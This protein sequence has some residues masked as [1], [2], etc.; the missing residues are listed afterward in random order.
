[1]N[2]DSINNSDDK[3]LYLNSKSVQGVYEWIEAAVFSLLCVSLIFTFVMR[4]VGV[5]GNSMKNTLYDSERLI[6][7]RSFYTPKRG[8]IIIIKRYPEEPLVKRI[9]AVGGDRLKIDDETNQVILNGKVLHEDY[10]LGV[11]WREG[12]PPEEQ[13]I[14]QGTVFVMGDNRQNS[15]DSRMMEQVGYVDVEDIMGKAIFRFFPLSRAGG[16]Y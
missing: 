16:L 5:D 9:I 3:I 13:V 11:T 12:F 4:I 6:I 10:I 14:P 1:M 2:A 15:A 8:D 7:S